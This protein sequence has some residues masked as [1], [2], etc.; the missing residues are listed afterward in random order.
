MA[1]SEQDP[2]ITADIAPKPSRCGRAITIS[3]AIGCVWVGYQF[4]TNGP[5]GSAHTISALEKYTDAEGDSESGDFVRELITNNDNDYLC[6]ANFVYEDVNQYPDLYRFSCA[7]IS[8]F[9]TVSSAS[10]ECDDGFALKCLVSAS[11]GRTSGSCSELT[12]NPDGCGFS[13]FGD[14][15]DCAADAAV[16]SGERVDYC[17]DAETG[18]EMAPQSGGGCLAVCTCGFDEPM[19]FNPADCFG[20]ETSTICSGKPGD[21]DPQNMYLPQ[22][23][24]DED[25]AENQ[26]CTLS[27]SMSDDTVFECTNDAQNKS[28]VY[29]DSING[30][31]MD[32]FESVAID[33]MY[34]DCAYMDLKVLAVCEATA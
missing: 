1:H 18:A 20:D 5:N 21:S 6:D 26:Q 17:I 2:L 32:D 14:A 16:C 34:D 31:L 24:W 22:R 25:C 19:F 15:V 13:F 10:L 9:S 12:A 28:N 27:F 23:V 8:S 3:I 7:Q 11:Y 4:M 29:F 33:Q 30:V